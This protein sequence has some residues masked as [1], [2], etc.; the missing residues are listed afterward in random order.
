MPQAIEE[1]DS[2]DV[3]HVATMVLEDGLPMTPEIAGL[4]W[5]GTVNRPDV[6]PETVTCPKIRTATPANRSTCICKSRHMW[7]WVREGWRLRRSRTN[8]AS[9]HFHIRS[10]VRSSLQ[11]PHSRDRSYKLGRRQWPEPATRLFAAKAD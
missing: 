2:A 6:W 7:C 10:L 5:V 8:S 3:V 9:R 4:L 11:R 1:D